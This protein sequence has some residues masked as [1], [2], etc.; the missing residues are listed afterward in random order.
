MIKNFFIYFFNFIK[1]Y[2]IN[3]KIKKKNK[4]KI[5]II[6]QIEHKGQFQFIINLLSRVLEDKKYNKILISS[7]NDL[8]FLRKKISNTKILIVKTNIS[9]HI[10]N[11]DICVKCNFEDTK[12]KNSISIY[13]GHGFL[14]KRNFI[15][16]KYFEDINHIFL[17]GPS[18]FKL[19]K[20]Y[21]RNARYNFKKLRFWKVGYPNYDDQINNVYNI[22]KIKKKLNI[23]NNKINVLY[24]PSWENNASLRSNSKNIIKIFSK[25]TKYNFIIKLHPTLLIKKESKSY[26]FYTGGINWHKKFIFFEKKYSNIYYYKELKINPLFKIAKIMITDFSSVGLG[27]MLENK[28]VI[29]YNQKNL[30]NNNLISLGYDKHLEK[31]PLIN[32]GMNYGL[33]INNICDIGFSI[34]FLIKNK[35]FYLKKSKN[36]KKNL[37]YNPGKASELYYKY[38]NRI[39]DSEIKL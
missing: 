25:L 35:K 34:N 30:I 33:K 19:M 10:K 14:G 24:S 37:L 15:P 31:N 18:Y 12:P 8:D 7:N 22:S 23:T 32:N 38:L 29:F 13:I 3:D 27:F 2:K 16:K 26:K 20:Y 11:V 17:Y 28:P 36:L 5:N 4:S 1:I 39:I 21:I 9:Y 6:F